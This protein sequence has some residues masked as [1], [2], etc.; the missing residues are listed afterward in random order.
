MVTKAV[1][2]EESSDDPQ[3]KEATAEMLAVDA[4][5]DAVDNLSGYR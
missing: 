2:N 5:D 1:T 4:A 3:A